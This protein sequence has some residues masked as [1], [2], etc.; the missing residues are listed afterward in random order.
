MFVIYHI[1]TKK[2]LSFLYNHVYLHDDI[3]PVCVFNSEK[4][5]R[6]A[7][8]SRVDKKLGVWNSTRNRITVDLNIKNL[9]VM[10]VGYQTIGIKPYYRYKQDEMRDAKHTKNYIPDPREHQIKDAQ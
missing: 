2:Y 8:N 3:D 1:P 10:R 5:Y 6:S 7:V 4:K 9:R